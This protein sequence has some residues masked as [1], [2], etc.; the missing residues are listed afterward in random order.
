MDLKNILFG[1]AIIILTITSIVYGVNTF[2]KAPEYGDFCPLD[3]IPHAFDQNGTRICPTVCVPTYEIQNN[4]CFLNECGSGCGPDGINSFDS[5][6]KCE[7][8]LQGKNC[9]GLYEEAYESYSKNIFLIALPIG[10]LIIAIGAII[11]GLE[12]VGAGLMGGGVGIIIWGVSGFWRFADN[13]LKFFLSLI[14]LA[15]L[16]WLTYYFNKKFEKKKRRRKI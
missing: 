14:G 3:R 11:F 16:I 5:A 6:Q 7:L 2:Y 15:I 13:W 12:T 8:A 9:Y 1:I 10:I 4:S